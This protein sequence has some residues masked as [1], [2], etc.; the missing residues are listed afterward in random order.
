MEWVRQSDSPT[1]SR[2]LE[3]VVSPL[4]AILSDSAHQA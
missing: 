3:L 1:R 4:V 2:F